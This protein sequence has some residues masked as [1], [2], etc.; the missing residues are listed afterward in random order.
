MRR[1]NQNSDAVHRCTG[2]GTERTMMMPTSS[3]STLPL[4]NACSRTSVCPSGSFEFDSGDVGDLPRAHFYLLDTRARRIFVQVRVRYSYTMQGRCPP[5]LVSYRRPRWQRG[6]MRCGGTC[7]QG[8][9]VEMGDRIIYPLVEIMRKKA[10]DAFGFMKD[11]F[12]KGLEN[13]CHSTCMY[14]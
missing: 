2:R 4:V 5:R 10:T 3:R 12:A 13:F 6:I 9:D 14:T 7:H 1:R 11:F 8:L